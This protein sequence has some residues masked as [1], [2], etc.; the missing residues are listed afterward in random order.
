MSFF[1]PRVSA[2]LN[3]VEMKSTPQVFVSS[4]RW[5]DLFC[6]SLS[7]VST[8]HCG[9]VAHPSGAL[10]VGRV[11]KDAPDSQGEHLLEGPL[12]AWGWG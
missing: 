6:F 2:L 1:S 12:L 9:A 5:G 11:E 3:S 7:H 4:T 10:S 8:H